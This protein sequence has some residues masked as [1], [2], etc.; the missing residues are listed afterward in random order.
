[1]LSRRW[2]GAGTFLSL[3]LVTGC[4][5]SGP[6]AA[7]STLATVGGGAI[8]SE[9]VMAL[10]TPDGEMPVRLAAGADDLTEV[11]DPLDQA[12]RTAVTDELLAREADREGIDGVNRAQR[13]SKLLDR[14][15]RSQE[16]EPE[17]AQARAW[18]EG[19]RYLFDPVH[20]ASVDY[21][22]LGSAAHLDEAVTGLQDPGVDPEAL[23]RRFAAVS[24]G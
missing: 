24:S 18:Y 1:M 22:V 8:T 2:L 15:V 21:L 13:I 20:A 10:L 17:E 9:E 19:H 16:E 12:L 14:H 11:S 3:L 4:S 23:G 6:A 5:G 7:E